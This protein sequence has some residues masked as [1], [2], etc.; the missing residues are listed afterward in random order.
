MSSERREII[1]IE[2]IARI[3]RLIE[4][5]QGDTGRLRYI[6]ETLQKG[7][8][9]FRSDRIYLERKID[10]VVTK[11]PPKKPSIQN[12]K[13]RNVKLMLDYKLG[14]PGRLKFI[15]KTL[16]KGKP[17]YSSDEK[18]LETKSNLLPKPPGLR[19]PKRRVVPSVSV[20][21]TVK[22]PQW[23]VINQL[24]SELSIGTE[25]IARL[26]TIIS[27]QHIEIEKLRKDYSEV[28]PPIEKKI[29]IED[30]SKI[31]DEHQKIAVLKQRSEQIDDQ[32]SQLTQLIIYRQ[33]YERKVNREKILLEDE[34]RKEKQKIIEKDNLVGELI[35]KQSELT[36]TRAEREVL[37][38]Q[39]KIDKSKLD[40]E[41]QKQREELELLKTEY[42]EI[43]SKIKYD[44][45]DIK[46]QIKR[47]METI[48]KLKREISK[49]DE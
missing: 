11:T 46:D 37:L 2:A 38:E 34:I 3:K 36:K 30:I 7:K 33:E 24:K 28:S 20:K 4:S 39:I 26:K 31:E 32:R 18:Y 8:E 47:I 19:R 5:N 10:A 49:N 25:T 1:A 13:L 43:E 17:L 44:N 27:S 48:S 15:F 42:E 40:S 22:G 14:D 12:Q 45:L 16:Q 21:P 9:L 41:L 23:D 6:I 29:D 35:K